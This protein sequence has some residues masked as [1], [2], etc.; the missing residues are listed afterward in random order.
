MVKKSATTPQPLQYKKPHFVSFV[1]NI[2]LFGCITRRHKEIKCTKV[3]LKF[4]KRLVKGEAYRPYR[5][6]TVGDF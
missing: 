3:V 4:K 2:P 6:G 1:F 5:L